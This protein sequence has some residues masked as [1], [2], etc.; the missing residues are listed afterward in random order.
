MCGF[1]IEITCLIFNTLIIFLEKKIFGETIL[2]VFM[3]LS[4][5]LDRL[6]QLMHSEM[7]DGWP[8]WGPP[9]AGHGGCVVASIRSDGDDTLRR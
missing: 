6:D 2:L 7:D 9:A 1:N 3:Q 8:S 5:Q 4:C